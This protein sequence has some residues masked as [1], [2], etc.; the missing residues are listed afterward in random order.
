[1]EGQSGA[2]VDVGLGECGLLLTLPI[3]Y[4]TFAHSTPYSHTCWGFTQIL[5]IQRKKNLKDFLGMCRSFCI[6]H[7]SSPFHDSQ[8]QVIVSQGSQ[9]KNYSPELAHMMFY[10]L[11]LLA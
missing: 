2:V 10:L 11:L 9:A 3:G 6:N 1:M 4:F 5:V 7:S 8:Q